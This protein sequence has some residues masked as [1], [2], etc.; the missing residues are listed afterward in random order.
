MNPNTT[1]YSVLSIKKGKDEKNTKPQN[2]QKTREPTPE[3]RPKTPIPRCKVFR[4]SEKEKTKKTQNPKKPTKNERM[5][6]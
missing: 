5:D 2:R 4:S 3:S 1:L 6:P